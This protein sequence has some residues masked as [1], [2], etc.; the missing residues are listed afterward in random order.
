MKSLPKPVDEN[1]V[2]WD[3]EAVFLRCVTRVR[4]AERKQRLESIAPLIGEA[5]EEFDSKAAVQLLHRI[6]QTAKV[7]GT[8]SNKEMVKTYDDRFVPEK[9]P[10]RE[11]YDRIKIA[12]PNSRCPLCVAGSIRTLDHHLP[13][14][15]YSELTVTPNNLVPSCERCQS[16]KKSMAPSSKRTQTFHPY[17]DNFNDKIWLVA[18]VVEST[19]AAFLFSTARPV[20][21]SQLKANRAAHHFDLLELAELYSDL[22]A[23]E[24]SGMKK[25]LRGLFRDGGREAVRARLLEGE[26]S[27]REGFRN[28]WKAAFY[29]AAAASDWFCDGGFDRT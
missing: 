4:N 9:S 27:W 21:W 28:H 7:A 17:F 18:V 22:A 12:P 24:C 5:A 11:I 10:G 3:A 8:V 2:E 6:P 26:D 16:L 15:K 1:G 23:D 14:T 29:A 13:K 20:G 25:A 19:P